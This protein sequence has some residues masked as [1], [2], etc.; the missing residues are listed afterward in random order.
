MLLDILQT[1]L[2]DLARTL[3]VEEVCRHVRTGSLR[4]IQSGKVLKQKIAAKRAKRNRRA[5]IHKMRTGTKPK[6]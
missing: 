1:F 6:L 4:V 3:L 2:M 5:S